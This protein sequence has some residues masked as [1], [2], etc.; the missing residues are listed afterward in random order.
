MRISGLGEGKHDFS[1]ELDRTFFRSFAQ[2]EVENGN[3]RAGVILEKK[4][5]MMA[6][7]FEL[8]GEIEVICDR[9]LEPFMTAIHASEVIY[10]KEGEASEETE[11]NI[12]II[13]KDDHEVAVGQLLYEFTVLALPFRRMH[14][15]DPSGPAALYTHRRFRP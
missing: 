6:L 13:G 15:D 2:S 10:L 1:F 14:R 11:E 4:P 5:G 8:S 9:C 3:V 7:H 12:M